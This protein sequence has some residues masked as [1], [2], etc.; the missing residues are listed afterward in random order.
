[1]KT[2]DVSARVEKDGEL[3]I[4]SEELRA[5][6]EVD[7]KLVI[8]NPT[9]PRHTLLDLRGIFKGTWGSAEAIDRYLEEERNSWER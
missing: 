6:Q 8:R 3:H 1:M 5:G 4:C 9:E 2:V 7:V